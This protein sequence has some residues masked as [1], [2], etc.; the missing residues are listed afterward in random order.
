[1]VKLTQAYEILADP[2]KRLI[3]DRELAKSATKARQPHD[4]KNRRSSSFSS[5]S[6][7]FKQKNEFSANP[8][9]SSTSEP[10]D[11]LEDLLKDVEEMLGQF[12]L[13][14][15]DPLEMLVEWARN[16]FQEITE[17]A[18]DQTD[19]NKSY[20][21]QNKNAQTASTYKEPLDNLEAELERLKRE[22]NAGSK[23]AAS[24]QANYTENEIEEE[25]RSIKKKYKL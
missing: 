24:A 7:S 19:N 5:T 14:F 23:A 21:Q 2:Q 4:Q 9:K 25:L 12:G 20:R 16:I 17:T 18:N 1:F 8:Q 15:K 6:S 3:F 10:E 13:N 22:I 11:S